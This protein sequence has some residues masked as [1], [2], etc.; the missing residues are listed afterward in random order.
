MRNAALRHLRDLDEAPARGFTWDKDRAQH[1]LDFFPDVLRLN[2][3]QFE[4]RPFELHP[5]QQFIVG[6]LFGW[7]RADG[8]RRFRRA[9]IEIAKGNG[10]SPLAA[11]IGMFCLL[12]DSEP[13]AEVYA[14]ASKMDQAR[15]L[16]RDAVAMYQQ[17]PDLHERL[18]PSGGAEV[19]N[20]ADPQTGSWFRPIASDRGQSGPRPSCALCDELHEHRDGTMIEMLERGFK[21]RRSPLLVMITNSGS[22]RTSA[23]WEEHLHAVRVAAGTMAPDDEATFVGEPIDDQAFSFVCSVDHGEDPF[24]DPS[25]WGKANPLLGVTVQPD[26]LQG[27]VKQ[28]LQIPGKMNNIARLHFCQWTDADSAWLSRQALEE[29][30]ADFEPREHYGARAFCGLDLSATRDLTALAFVVPTGFR[31]V[32]RQDKETGLIRSVSLP[33][34]D[35]WVEAWTPQDTLEERARSDQAPY[36]VWARQGWL[37]AIPGKVIRYDHVAARLAEAAQEYEIAGLAFDAYAFRKAFEPELDTFGINVKLL[38]H[39]QGGRRKAPETGLWMPGSVDTLETLILEQRIR[40]Q[41][42]P[43][44]I[45]AIMSGAIEEDAFGNR[46]FAKRKATNR[47]DPLVSLAMGVGAADAGDDSRSAYDTRGLLVI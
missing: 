24:T 46:W 6:S 14:A 36:D 43:V 9:Y 19:W 38:E 47:I 16:F 39:P 25:C 22:D 28:A 13:R 4:G 45:S 37:T 35:A 32:D 29:C 18:I 26:Y 1:A 3:G 44:L 34:F 31:I 40:I 5:S 42:S 15:V 41:R 8:T 12:A 30:L 2:G 23:C 27:V 17:S 20:L 33:T 21:W 10:K 11:G 7:I